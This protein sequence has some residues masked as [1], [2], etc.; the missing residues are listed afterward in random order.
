MVK[1]L[2]VTSCDSME[3]HEVRRDVAL[4]ETGGNTDWFGA[5]S[6]VNPAWN[7]LF[8]FPFSELNIL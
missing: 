1:E 7:L 2:T 8:G 3:Y 4:A 5:R 6:Q